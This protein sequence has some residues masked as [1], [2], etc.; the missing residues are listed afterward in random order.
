MRRPATPGAMLAALHDARPRPTGRR[1]GQLAGA[2]R[3]SARAWSAA[4]LA[5]TLLSSLAE[6]RQATNVSPFALPLGPPLVRREPEAFNPEGFEPPASAPSS[7]R[8]RQRRREEHGVAQSFIALE[9]MEGMHAHRTPAIVSAAVL[10]DG[11]TPVDVDV[12]EGPAGTH[13]MPHADAGS[14]EA[15]KVL[16]HV[17]GLL[18]LAVVVAVGAACA[19]WVRTRQPRENEERSRLMADQAE[20]EHDAA[21]S[22]ESDSETDQVAAMPPPPRRVGAEPSMGM[23]ALR[24]LSGGMSSMQSTRSHGRR[25]TDILGQVKD[26]GF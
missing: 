12:F 3:R 23:G 26:E 19:L 21:P 2:S 18:V 17:S 16:A 15:N 4:A 8:K 14:V 10:L 6:A 9:E 22:S 24:S 1:E 13:G 5:I 11:A 7:G 20:A 25:N